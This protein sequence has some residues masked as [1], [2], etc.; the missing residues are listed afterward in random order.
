MRPVASAIEKA[1]KGALR[2]PGA[3]ITS[4]ETTLEPLRFLLQS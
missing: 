2:L 4:R 3:T 1:G